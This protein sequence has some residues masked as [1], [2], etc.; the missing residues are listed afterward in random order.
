MPIVWIAADARPRHTGF[1]VAAT[2][3]VDGDDCLV[4]S[5]VQIYHDLVNEKL[6]QPLLGASI[7]TWCIPCLGQIGSPSGGAPRCCWAPRSTRPVVG[8]WLER[9]YI[10]AFSAVSAHDGVMDSHSFFLGPARRRC[11]YSTGCDKRGLQAV[12]CVQF[13]FARVAI[14]RTK[15]SGL[16]LNVVK[17]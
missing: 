1:G 15:V 10:Y 9:K 14:G 8:A 13:F 16:L 11:R 12:R 17:P 4:G 7:R 5:L 2:I 6:G 3:P